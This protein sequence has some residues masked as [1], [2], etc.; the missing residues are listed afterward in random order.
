MILVLTA[1]PTTP[2]TR[3]SYVQGPRFFPPPAKLH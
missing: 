2:E 1:I 3:A